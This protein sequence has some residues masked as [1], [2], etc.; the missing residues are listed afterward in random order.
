MLFRS[1]PDPR[2]ASRIEGNLNFSWAGELPE[3]N[4]LVEGTWWD[5]DTQEP[6]VSL[7]Q[8]WAEPLGVTVG[9]RIGVK[10]GAETID[11]RIVNIREV[12]WESFK[13]NFFVLFPPRVFAGAPH[14]FL[15]AIRIEGDRQKELTDLNRDF[16]TVNIVDI[17]AILA[18][19][20]HLLDLVGLALNFVFAFTLAAGAAVLFS[21]LQAGQ[22]SRVRDVAM[23]KVLG[24]NQLRLSAALSTEF[25]IIATVAGL[26]SG[27]AAWLT[28]W[29]L[30]GW[31]FDI[32]YSGNFL[33]LFL[34]LVVSVIIV[35]AVSYFGIRDAKRA[36]PQSVL[37]NLMN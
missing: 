19:V 27:L 9:D 31:V 13:P 32:P 36:S 37:R 21:V 18:Q 3:D 23:L 29:A 34:S 4:R 26:L 25:M 12:Q 7:A 24:C 35:W 16:P 20:R 30:A 28:G 1:Y 5:P 6:V 17:G 10:V 11:A 33:Q 2:T 22:D 14:G 8:S 15:S